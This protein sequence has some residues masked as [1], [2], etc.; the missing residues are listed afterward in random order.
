MGY[1]ISCKRKQCLKPIRSYGNS[2]SPCASTHYFYYSEF[3]MNLTFPLH[4]L[5]PAFHCFPLV[6]TSRTADCHERQTVRYLKNINYKFDFTQNS[7]TRQISVFH[8]FFWKAK[9]SQLSCYLLQQEKS[10]LQCCL[11]TTC[12]HLLFFNSLL[13]WLSC[14]SSSLIDN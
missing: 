3:V 10:V 5:L 6:L 8:I 11:H 13:S 1:L 9:I 7:W 14:C 2:L 12:G 4:L